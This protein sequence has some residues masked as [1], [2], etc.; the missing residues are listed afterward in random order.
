M[1]KK[2]LFALVALTILLACAVGAII[3]LENRPDTPNPEGTEAVLPSNGTEAPEIPAT[4]ENTEGAENTEVTEAPIEISLPTED[5]SDVM[6]EETFGEEDE[7]PPVTVDPEATE[8]TEDRE[9]NE[10]P[11]DVFETGD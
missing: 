5:P 3:F 11:E 7:V 2:L 8:G 6:P 9:S 10:T 1:K 4:D